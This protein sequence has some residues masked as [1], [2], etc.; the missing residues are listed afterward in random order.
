VEEEPGG[1]VVQ[2]GRASKT[3]SR[4]KSRANKSAS[5]AA[6]LDQRRKTLTS[7]AG[8]RDTPKTGVQSTRRQSL[9]RLN[10]TT[11]RE[12]ASISQR[13]RAS[14]KK[15]KKEAKRAKSRQSTKSARTERDENEEVDQE[16]EVDSDE[17]SV[18]ERSAREEENSN[19]EEEENETGDLKSARSTKH[20]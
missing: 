5:P 4:P 13:S 1:T 20:D 7:S 11:G 9:S 18:D 2:N 3:G 12:Q 16:S 19:E 10:V 6:R 15:S 17:Q 8:L 14:S